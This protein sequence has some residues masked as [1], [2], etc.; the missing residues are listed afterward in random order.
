MDA[1]KKIG[2]DGYL[3]FEY[4]HPFSHYPEALI[5]Q[6]ADALARLMGEKKGRHGA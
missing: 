6:T 3:T 4:F 5:H 1:F 2:Y